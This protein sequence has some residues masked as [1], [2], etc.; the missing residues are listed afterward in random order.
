MINYT[1]QAMYVCVTS[2]ERFRDSEMVGLLWVRVQQK[3]GSKT[4]EIKNLS[5]RFS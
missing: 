2:E 5:A 3:E 4:K 1:R